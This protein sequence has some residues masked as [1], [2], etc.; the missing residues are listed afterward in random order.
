MEEGE[1]KAVR[2]PL[3]AVKKVLKIDGGFAPKVL[4]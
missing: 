2:C 4:I 1:C 3:T